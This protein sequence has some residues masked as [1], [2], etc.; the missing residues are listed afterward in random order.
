VTTSPVQHAPARRTPGSPPREI[1]RALVACPDARPPAYEAVA[2][3]AA[4]GRL[5]RFVTGIY[6]TGSLWTRRL[7]G[8]SKLARRRHD[9][10]PADRVR[11]IPSFDVALQLETRLA[12]RSPAARRL[13]ARVRT[14]RF[15]RALAAIIRRDPPRAALM[16][17]DVGSRHALPT[18]NRLGIP[19]VLSMVHG[20]VREERLVLEREAD[21]A[22]DFFPIYLGD[23]ALDRRELDWLHARRLRDL[24]CADIVLVPSEHIAG[25][26]IRH[27]HPVDRVRVIP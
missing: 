24:A 15:D 9:G 22:P 11:S 13:L 20:D 7:I 14:D 12:R 21:R 5:D 25:W 23:G 8:G 3:L 17:S 6:D 18:C 19:A 10:I 26:L 16:F 2:G 1:R 27:G 4:S